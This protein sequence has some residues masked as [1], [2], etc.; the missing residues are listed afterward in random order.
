MRQSSMSHC[1]QALHLPHFLLYINLSSRCYCLS[2][3][4]LAISRPNAFSLWRELSWYSCFLFTWLFGCDCYVEWEMIRSNGDCL[5][6]KDQLATML[7][8]FCARH[9]WFSCGSGIKSNRKTSK[10]ISSSCK[11]HYTK[12]KENLL[13]L[14]KLTVMDWWMQWPK[15]FSL[16]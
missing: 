9:L 8:S 5:P 11:D 6:R 4:I 12:R 7:A 13:T 14:R 15:I 10:I 2:N 1:R 3:C 16:L